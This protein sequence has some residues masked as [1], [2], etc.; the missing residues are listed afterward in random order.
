MLLDFNIHRSHSSINQVYYKPS[1]GFNMV[2]YRCGSNTTEDDQKN[3][4][5]K[6]IEYTQVHTVCQS[7]GGAFE[8][9]QTQT[10]AS[11]SA[12][13]GPGPSDRSALANLKLT[14]RVSRVL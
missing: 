8:C 3:I 11:G 7:C 14:L 2:C 5:E 10:E 4:D 9:R 13:P 12:C 1:A 6:L